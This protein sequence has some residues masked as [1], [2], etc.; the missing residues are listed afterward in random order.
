M[1]ATLV[2][3][4]GKL[5]T[6]GTG[7]VTITMPSNFT[8]GNAAIASGCRYEGDITSLTLNGSTATV[9]TSSAGALSGVWIRHVASLTG[10]SNSGTLDT[11]G[12][13]DYNTFSV[14]EWSGLDAADLVDTTA[15]P[16]TGSSTAPGVTVNPS[17]TGNVIYGCWDAETGSSNLGIGLPSGYTGAWTE[18]DSNTYQGGSG[19]Y[20]EA[21]STGSQAVTW[22]TGTSINWRAVGA[23]FAV[24]AG[25]PTEYT[26]SVSGSITATGAMSTALSLVRSY[27]A[28]ITPSG[29]LAAAATFARA[30][31]ATI[32]ATGA[33]VKMTARAIAGSIAAAGAITKQIGKGL[34]G[35]IESAGSAASASVRLAALVGSLTASGSLTTEKTE[36]GGLSA[37]PYVIFRRRR[38]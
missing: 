18:N 2:Q 33:V 31:T 26:Q 15:T 29:S 20:R 35:S 16:A 22:S 7:D 38:R 21:A 9:T 36:G 10:G 6:A 32:T 14:E 1:A 34:A 3:T 24:D 13:S 30:Y 4:S 23:V 8:A 27:A 37:I 28:S 17:A 5:R 25:G 11:P 19:A 12:G